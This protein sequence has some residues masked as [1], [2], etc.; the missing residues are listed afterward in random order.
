[1]SDHCKIRCL[2]GHLHAALD[3]LDR[4]VHQKVYFAW[5]LL[6]NRKWAH[7]YPTRFG[8]YWVENETQDRVPKYSAPWSR[9]AITR[10]GVTDERP[11]LA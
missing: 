1:V 9:D 5:P 3:A 2:H 7:G 11:L 8:L 6:D 10:H 4:G